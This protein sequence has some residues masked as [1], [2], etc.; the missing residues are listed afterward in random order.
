MRKPN[1]HVI[2]VVEDR[3]L[4]K[5]EARAAAAVKRLFPDSGALRLYRTAEGRIG[6]QLHLTLTLGDRQ[7]LDQAYRA[8]MKA[9]GERRGRPRGVKTVQTKLLLPEPVYRSLCELGLLGL[10]QRLET[11]EQEFR[12]ELLDVII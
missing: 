6:V 5:K 9:V 3:E 4:R 11:R 2:E 7:R 8:I 12:R 10:D 1:L